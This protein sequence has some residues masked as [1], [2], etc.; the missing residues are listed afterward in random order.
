MARRRCIDM[1][2]LAKAVT[3][4]AAALAAAACSSTP[5]READV[6]V[7]AD[8]A[9]LR[10]WEHCGGGACGK[11]VV[12]GY[13]TFVFLRVDDQPQGS[14][15]AVSLAPGRH[16]VEAYYAW[17]AGFLTGV[18]NWRNY[19]FEIEVQHGHAYAIEAAPSGCIVPAKRH[20]VSPKTLRVFDTAPSGERTARDVKAVEYCTPDS[21]EPGTCR[22]GSDCPSEPCTPFG[23]ETGYGLCGELRPSST[24]LPKA[25]SASRAGWTRR[26]M[27]TAWWK[28]RR[29]RW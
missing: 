23:G 29:S 4:L 11:G 14:A 18:G 5:T 21:R 10:G 20:W 7:P 22:Q 28:A 2:N 9:V 17:G 16:W 25:T 19:G 12:S 26:S 3:I 1:D 24:R 13:S 6:R 15:A 27:S 8:Q